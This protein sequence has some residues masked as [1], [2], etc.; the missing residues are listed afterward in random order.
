MKSGFRRY[1]MSTAPALLALIFGMTPMAPG[2]AVETTL[3]EQEV[4]LLLNTAVSYHYHANVRR[5]TTEGACYFDPKKPTTVE[6]SWRSNAPGADAFRLRQKVKQNAVKWCKKAGGESCVELFRNGTLRYDGL[7]PEQTQRLEDVLESIPSYGHEATPL[8]DDSTIRK[9]LFHERFAQMQGHWE[10][11]RKKKKTKRHFAMCANEQGTGVRFN[12]QGKIKQLPHVR[13]MCILQCQAVARWENTEGECHTIFENGTFTSPAAQRAMRLEVEP[14]SPEIRD[15][16]VGTWKGIN[17]R[18]ISIETDIVDVDPDGNVAGTGCSEYSNGSLA[19]KTLGEATFVNGD[20]IT[21]MNGNV[22]LTLMMNATQGETAE[23]VQTWPNG[24]QSRFPMQAMST[25]GCNERFMRGPNTRV[26]EQK[27][28]DAPIVGAWSGQW[29]NGTVTELV[30]ESVA[31]E[32]ALTGRY[33]HKKT[34]GLQLW[35]L[36]ADGPVKGTLGKK[37]KKA[38]MTIPWGRGNRDELE[39]RLKGTDKVTLKH[40]ERAGTS[41][42]KVTTLKM[43]RGASLDGCLM[44]TTRR[45]PPG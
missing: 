29:K 14:A 34:W 5:K 24:W 39:F 35:D 19:W 27:A 1:T 43:T 18:G 31:P 22:R 45:P 3:G 12:M 36:G 2:A 37:G 10:D 26:E 30:I 11:W 20:R 42:Q 4:R 17:H 15:A 40:K 7:S 33:C 41:K 32:G 13:A 38:K 44:R 28:D 25:R 6:C 21:M 16:F 23:T 9:G 8:P